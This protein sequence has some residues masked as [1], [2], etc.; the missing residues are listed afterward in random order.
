VKGL[1]GVKE[2]IVKSLPTYPYRNKSWTFKAGDISG[3]QGDGTTENNYKAHQGRRC[4]E[5]TEITINTK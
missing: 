4:Q 3:T 5:R 1:C 2:R